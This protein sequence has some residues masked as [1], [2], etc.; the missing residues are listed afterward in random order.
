MHREG[1]GTKHGSGFEVRIPEG[2]IGCPNS[3]IGMTD[4]GVVI[5]LLEHSPQ[6]ELEVYAAYNALFFR[7]PAEAV[8]S[9][10]DWLRQEEAQSGSVAVVSRRGTRLG[11]LKAIRTVVRYR[12]KTDGIEM[13]T[14]AL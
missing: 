3:P 11:P 1:D 5:P 12:T 13:V 6:G 8:G 4:H 2:L 14:R 7:N 9:D 10:I